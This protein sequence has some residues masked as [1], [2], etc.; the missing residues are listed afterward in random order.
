MCLAEHFY[1]QM[2]LPVV[3]RFW[4]LVRPNLMSKAASAIA[5]AGRLHH[6]HGIP[7]NSYSLSPQ[8]A[9]LKLCAH[10]QYIQ[11]NNNNNN[12]INNILYIQRYT[13]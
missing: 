13:P 7:L 2:Q 5:M 3:M 8:S 10:L 11:S 1:F 4:E 9:S 12:N 6:H